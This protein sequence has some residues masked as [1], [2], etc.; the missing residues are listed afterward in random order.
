MGKVN[1]YSEGDFDG[2]DLR[3]GVAVAYKLD[4]NGNKSSDA[5]AHAFEADAIVKVA[6]F[7]ANGAFTWV[8][9][10]GADSRVGFHVQAGWLAVPGHGQ[11]VARFAMLPITV[12]GNKENTLEVRGGLNWY[13][14]GHGL[15]WLT[16]F[17]IQKDTTDGAARDY[18][19]R[20]QGQIMF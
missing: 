5:W 1:G 18:Q 4:L 12:A 8:K 2:G 3:L 10:P 14:F 7:D 19:F 9:E 6:G 20:T 16:D 11:I 15:K 17:G 13:F